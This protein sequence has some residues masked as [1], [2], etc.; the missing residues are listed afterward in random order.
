MLYPLLAQLFSLLLDLFPTWRRRDQQKDRA[1]LV[2]RQQLR[3]LQR[4]HPTAPCISRWEK[5]GLAVLAAKF[6]GLGRGAKSHLNQ[7]LLLFKPD[8]VL[9]WQRE[10]VRRKW[11]FANQPTSGRPV[12]S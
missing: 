7:V 2:L 8:T 4:P 1:I 6:T 10:L 12:T 11:T 5:R 3:I 9:R